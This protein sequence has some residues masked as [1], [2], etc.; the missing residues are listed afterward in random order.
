MTFVL[1]KMEGRRCVRL[2]FDG[3]VT[4]SDLEQSRTILKD[5]LR[6]SEGTRKVLVDMRKASLD[7][8]TI[9]VHQFVSSHRNELPADLLIAVIV[10]PK[11]WAISIFAENVAHNRMTYMRVFRDDLHACAW[12]GIHDPD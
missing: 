2:E 1:E 9:D 6:E 10:Q 3:R 4:I 7:V 8:S 11:D 12:L 5:I